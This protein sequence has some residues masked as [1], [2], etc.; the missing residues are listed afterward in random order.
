MDP[1]LVS[2]YLAFLQSL[3]G[4]GKSLG[5]ARP[6]TNAARLNEAARERKEDN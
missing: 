6:D 2:A 4:V 1:A 3:S 5:T